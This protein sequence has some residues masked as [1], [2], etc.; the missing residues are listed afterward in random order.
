MSRFY[1]SIIVHF[2]LP[3]LIVESNTSF[4]E[5][6]LTDAQHITMKIIHT[7][8]ILFTIFYYNFCFNINSLIN[9][10]F[11][12]KI[13][14][15]HNFHIFFLLYNKTKLYPFAYIHF[16]LEL[17]NSIMCLYSFSAHSRPFPAKSVGL[18]C[19]IP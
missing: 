6:L 9:L 2:Y 7:S 19:C 11:Y 1:Y 8:I 10:Q 3:I 5:A 16:F 12:S 4:F 17:S 14:H 13:Y 15:I 18:K